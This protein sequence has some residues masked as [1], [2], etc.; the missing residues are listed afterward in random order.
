MKCSICKKTLTRKVIDLG[1]APITNN[2]LKKLSKKKFNNSYPLQVHF[3]EKCWLVQNKYKLDPKKIFKNDYP[4]FSSFSSSWVKHAENYT[5]NIVKR[6]N[7][8]K[9]SLVAEVASNDGYLLQFFKK[10]K[11]PCYGVE[12]TKSTAIVAKKKGIKTFQKFFNIKTAQSLSVKFKADLIIANNVLAHVPN[13]RNFIESFKILLKENGIATFEFHYLINLI[14]K[15]QFDTIYHEHYFYHSLISLDKIFK[16]FGLRI[17]DAENLKSHGGSLRI[18]VKKENNSQFKITNRLKKLI[19]YEIKIGVNK[20][21]FYK[22]L[23]SEAIKIKNKFYSFLKFCNNNKKTVIGYGAAAKGITLINFSKVNSNMLKYIIDKNPKK[24]N[25]FLS[26][27]NIKIVNTKIL[28][29]LKP[30]YV[31][32]LPWNLKK[33]VIKELNFIKKWGGK[34]VVFVP[35]FKMF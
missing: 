2:L 4:Y 31:I 21:S 29:T 9:S 34:F 20:L 15:N 25:K 13:L 16:L 22:K 17:F 1:K 11:I 32:I 24:Q 19:N 18:Y 12:P 27:S 35:S 33:E 5:K 23:Q 6:F 26:Q 10:R 30:N 3:C 7:L 28:K 14:K 8:N